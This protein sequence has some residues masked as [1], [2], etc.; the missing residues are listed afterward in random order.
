MIS[1]DL[2]ALKYQMDLSSNGKFERITKL[3]DLNIS[4]FN[5]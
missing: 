1:S 4:L 3:E 2:N 5:I